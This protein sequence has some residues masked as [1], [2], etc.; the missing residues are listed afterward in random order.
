[1][2]TLRRS[3]RGHGTQVVSCASCSPLAAKTTFFAGVLNLTDKQP[4]Y[5]YSAA[6][7]NSDP[8]TY[9][10]VGRYFYGRVQHKF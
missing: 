9:D 2:P 6:L 5:I 8:N 4:P 3:A 7:A 10:Y 1:L